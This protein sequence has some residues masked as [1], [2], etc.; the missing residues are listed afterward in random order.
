MNLSDVELLPRVLRL[1]WARTARPEQLIPPGLDWFVWLIDAGRGFGKTRT[2]AETAREW[3]LRKPIRIAVVAPT[4]GDVRKTCYEGESGLINIIPPQLIK[5]YNSSTGELV[6]IN[7]TMF[8]GYSAEEPERLRG[9][10]H[11]K[12][13]CDEVAAW[14][15]PETWDQLVFGLRLKNGGNVPQIVATTTPKPVKL[16]R[17]LIARSQEDG[18]RVI[19]TGGSTFDNAA[20][21]SEFALDEL[22]KRYEGTRLGMQELYA[23]LLEDTPGALWTTALLEE[24][25]YTGSAPPPVEH[26]RIP[27]DPAVTS[28]EN[29]DETGLSA[30][31]KCPKEHGYV[32]EDKSGK[33]SPREWAVEAVKLYYKWKRHPGVKSC[34]IVGEVNNGGDLIE[35]NIRQV[36]A[37]VEYKAVRASKGKVSRAEPI[38]TRYERK[39]I[40]HWGYFPKLEEQ[41]CAFT[42]D[43]DKKTMGYSP[44]RVD[45]IVWGFSD[46]FVENMNTGFLDFVKGRTATPIDERIAVNG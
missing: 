41:M 17:E 14:R 8:T 23:A 35:M 4:F 11:H 12:A 33:H 27:I 26:V 40:H 9:P 34:K 44:D 43:F 3:G 24:T 38:A 16:I 39:L 29:S 6:L 25:R 2:G 1:N 32:L 28:G 10:Q 18:G 21:L 36:D 42:T 5:K 30:V 13:W 37:N 22:K 15:Y 19:V 20:N 45:S 7:G 31:G 46:L